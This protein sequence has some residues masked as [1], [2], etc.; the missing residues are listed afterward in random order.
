VTDFSTSSV[1]PV[2]LLVDFI[3]GDTELLS[4]PDLGVRHLRES[5]I[6]GGATV[7]QQHTHQ[8][9]PGGYSGVLLLAQS[10]AS[11]H[12]WPEDGLVSIDVF[13]CGPMDINAML[14]QL[15]ERFSPTSERVE[16]VRRGAVGLDRDRHTTPRS[17]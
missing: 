17:A 3:S 2:H 4:E 9:E 5:V 6:A 13:G 16:H 12:T 1:T 10:H 8:F 15:R 11:I 7:L 14:V